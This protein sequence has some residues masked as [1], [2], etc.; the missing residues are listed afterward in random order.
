M[1]NNQLTVVVEHTQQ[2]IAEFIARPIYVYANIFVMRT[3][4]NYY[5]DSNF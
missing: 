1:I 5:L 4:I 3:V 2:N